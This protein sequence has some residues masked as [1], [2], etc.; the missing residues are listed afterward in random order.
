[1]NLKNQRE[2]NLTKSVANIVARYTPAKRWSECRDRPSLKIRQQSSAQQ[3]IS[4]GRAAVLL[5]RAV[6]SRGPQ[7]PNQRVPNHDAGRIGPSMV[8]IC[9]HFIGAHPIMNSPV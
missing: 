1:M 6:L 4:L 9:A 8:L 2:I 3:I 7:H 5:N